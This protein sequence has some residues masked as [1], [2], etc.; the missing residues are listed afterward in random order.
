MVD[1]LYKLEERSHLG[2]GQDH[3]HVSNN[4]SPCRSRLENEHLR[5]CFNC[6]RVGEAGTTHHWEQGKLGLNYPVR[7][8]CIFI[9]AHQRICPKLLVRR[10]RSREGRSRQSWVPPPIF[11]TTM[12]IQYR[13]NI[14]LLY[15]PTSLNIV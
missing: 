2:I 3:Y 15:S 9:K 8:F 13:T 7:Q 10:V 14:A 4:Q 12:Q 1:V 6:S 11:C 5:I